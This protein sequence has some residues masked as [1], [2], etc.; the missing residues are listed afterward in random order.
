MHIYI[1]VYICVHVDFERER[2]IGL[3][4]WPD[5]PRHLK[6]EKHVTHELLQDIATTNSA[7]G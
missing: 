2:Y 6:E 3:I 5:P 7:S 4:R 1:Y